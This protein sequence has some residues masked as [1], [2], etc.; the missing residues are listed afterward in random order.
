MTS[1]IHPYVEDM[2]QAY[3]DNK[4][5]DEEVALEIRKFVRGEK[6]VNSLNQE[7]T[8]AKKGKYIRRMQAIAMIRMFTKFNKDLLLL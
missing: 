2:I 1:N 5:F 3:V 4:M 6:S 8:V 7:F